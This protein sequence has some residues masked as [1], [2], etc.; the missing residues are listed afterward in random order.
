MD[1]GDAG[2]CAGWLA[3]LLFVLFS[4]FTPFVQAAVRRAAINATETVIINLN[5]LNDLLKVK[6]YLV[7][8]KAVA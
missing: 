2:A 4:V 3:W 5:I 7:I 8:V 1:V 6:W